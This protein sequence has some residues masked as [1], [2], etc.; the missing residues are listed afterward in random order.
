M[1][2]RPSAALDDE[3][4]GDLAGG[5]GDADEVGAG[6]TIGHHA[7]SN[8]GLKSVTIPE[9]VT[10]IGEYAFENCDALE[11]A[12]VANDV[13]CNYEFTDCDVLTTVT[14]ASITSIGMGAF[15]F[16]GLEEFAIGSQVTE[17]G[18]SAFASSYLEEIAIPANV[19]EIGEG[20]FYN[21]PA[22]DTLTVD[23]ANPNYSADA[24]VLYNKDGSTLIC[25][26]AGIASANF[27][28]PLAVTRIESNAFFAATVS[29]IVLPN[30]ILSIGATPFRG[31]ES[32][33]GFLMLDGSSNPAE[34]YVGSNYGVSQGVLYTADYSTLIAFPAQL[35]TKLYSTQLNT[36]VIAD[37][38][39]EGAEGLEFI[40]LGDPDNGACYISSVGTGAFRNCI[41]LNAVSLIAN[42]GGT[43]F[44]LNCFEGCPVR[45]L[46]F[47]G[48]NA[49]NFK[50][51][52]SDFNNLHACGID[53]I[54]CMDVSTWYTTSLNWNDVSDEYDV[55]QSG[56]YV[57]ADGITSITKMSFA[58]SGVRH[59]VIP[60]EVTSIG[61]MAFGNCYN[62]TSVTFEEGSQL[63]SIGKQAFGNC[64]ALESIEI[65]ASVTTIGTAPFAGCKKLQ[66]ISVATGNENFC[67]EGGVLYDIGKTRLI[68]YPSAKADAAFTAPTTLTSVDETAATSVT[69]LQ[70]L[71]FANTGALTIGK[72]A[73]ALSGLQVVA[74][75]GSGSVAI[76]DQ[77]FAGCTTLA[78]VVLPASFTLG[79][80]PFYGCVVLGN[81][82]AGEMSAAGVPFTMPV[83]YLGDLAG[84]QVAYAASAGENQWAGVLLKEDDANPFERLVILRGISFYLDHEPDATEKGT[85]DAAAAAFGNLIELSYWHYDGTTGMPTLWP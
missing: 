34:D 70:Q 80:A 51:L 1:N 20:A 12:T 54:I 11:N 58:A 36:R 38:A 23:A 30:T 78:Y 52:M 29:G 8:S 77:A 71:T 32:L 27:V 61:E 21:C 59:V 39:F 62:L 82:S 25:Y 4:L 67:A 16:S 40:F 22:L 44:G 47:I 73:F 72:Q 45:T 60:K 75:A 49:T 68:A 24:N 2:G 74:F 10:E 15:E 64:T 56:D 26:P 6:A 33:K 43:R 84:F 18:A 55:G 14:A 69:S 37:Y 17:I 28:V 83:F 79:I 35:P 53:T 50:F 3:L 19:E 57:F 41:N 81:L 7:F 31:C 66:T 76:G 5:G 13:I 48:T 42:V 85:L 46:N 65:P 63:K 9:T